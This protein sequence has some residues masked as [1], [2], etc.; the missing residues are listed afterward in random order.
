MG[1]RRLHFQGF[2]PHKPLATMPRS[3]PLDH[4]IVVFNA[5][6]QDL[7][8]ALPRHSLFKKRGPGRNLPGQLLG[9]VAVTGGASQH[10]FEWVHAYGKLTLQRTNASAKFD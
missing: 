5:A 3:Q 1:T 4:H 9:L 10:F 7:Q 6:V 8:S 2:Y